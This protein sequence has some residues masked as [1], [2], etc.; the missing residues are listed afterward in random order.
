MTSAQTRSGRLLALLDALRRRRRPVAG[1]ILAEEL[2]VSLRTLYRDIA[3]LNAGGATIEGEPGLGYVLRPGTFLPPLMLGDDE[4]DAVMLGLRFVQRRADPEL[5]EA[6]ARALARIAAA[7]PPGRAD[8][9][10]ESGLLAGPVATASPHLPLIRAALREEAR[11]RLHYADKKG[12]ETDRVVW[13][14]AV[15]FFEAAEVLVAWCET[16]EDFRHFRLD[17]IR[18]ASRAGG[19]I[20][21]HRRV[22][23]ADWRLA[24][25][26]GGED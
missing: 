3:T 19:R 13:P 9:A 4:A 11:L 6:A 26:L 23:L 20:P 21:R 25:A 17:R 10:A 7:L 24:E 14:V 5:A 1:A 18:E 8:A 12:R 2:G 22:L 16:R 15:G